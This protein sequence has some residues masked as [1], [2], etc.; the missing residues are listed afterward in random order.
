MSDHTTAPPRPAVGLTGN[1]A[2]APRDASAEED[3]E[4]LQAAVGDT[5]RVGR[6]IGQGQCSAVFR[7]IRTGKHTEVAL[8]LLDIDGTAQPDLVER[9]ADL[10][11]RVMGLIWDTPVVPVTIEQ[12]GSTVLLV[13]PLVETG[14]VARC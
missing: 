12:Y 7:A 13:M 5:Y 1:G 14:S 8:K 6:R 2:S 11:R 10:T 3:R 4:R 9:L